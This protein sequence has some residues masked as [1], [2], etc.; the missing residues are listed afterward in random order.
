VAVSLRS[1]VPGTLA[2]TAV[3]TA[4]TAL[5][6]LAGLPLGSVA[7]SP[8]ALDE[9]RLWLLVTSGLL[10][11]DPWL[12]SLVGF[13]IVLSCALCLLA[14]R[15]VIG[16]A[17]AGQVGS[18]LVV[19]GAIAAVRLVDPRAFSSLL[20]APDYG[21]SAI[22]AAWIGAVAAVAWRRFPTR[23]GRLGVV[24]GCLVCLGVGLACRPDVTFLDSEH[25]VAFGLGILV[26]RPVP[27][28]PLA[29]AWR[30]AAALATATWS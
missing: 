11:D 30:R 6:R 12:P 13:A 10:A 5:N 28:R 23:N 25:L 26:V 3:V 27:L 15:I 21:V 16:V 29:R 9:G 7:A 19:Y 8:R 22:I 1:A 18:A 2:G 17:A 4:G 24:A 20:T 14:P